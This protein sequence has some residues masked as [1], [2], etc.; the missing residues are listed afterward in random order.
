MASERPYSIWFTLANVARFA[1][2]LLLIVII[3][4]LVLGRSNTNQSARDA[5][6]E[7]FQT[8]RKSRV[9]ALIHRQETAS[10]LGIPV[11]SYISVEDSEA[12]LRVIR[13]TPPDQPIDL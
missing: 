7:Q 13:L 5:L 4:M 10:I 1:F 11:S 12:L 6:L 8:E 9:I 2:W 3:A